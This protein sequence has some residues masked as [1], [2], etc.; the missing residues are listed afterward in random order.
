MAAEIK[1]LENALDESQSIVEKLEMALSQEWQSKVHAEKQLTDLRNE[2]AHFEERANAA[3][4]RP[5]ELKDQQTQFAA[6]IKQNSLLQKDKVLPPHRKNLREL[7][8]EERIRK[9][10]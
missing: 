10:D 2:N 9:S 8:P 4:T 3:E 5:S 1:R 7:I 6:A